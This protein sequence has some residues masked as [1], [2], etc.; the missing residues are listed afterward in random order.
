MSSDF[1]PPKFEVRAFNCPHCN[2]YAKQD[3]FYE[4]QIPVELSD[5]QKPRFA[6]ASISECE[7]CGRIAVWDSQIVGHDESGKYTQPIWEGKMVF[8][9]TSNA[10]LPNDDMPDDIKMDYNE[11]R[12]IAAVSP[13]GA[14]ALLRLCIQKL[15]PVLGEKGKNLDQDIGALVKKGLNPQIQMALDNVRVI[16]NEAVH[17]G[18]M[19]VNDNLEIVLTL[20]DLL[21]YIIEQMISIPKKNRDLFANLPERKLGAIAKRDGKQPKEEDN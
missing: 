13:R 5:L 2:V 4:P 1:V 17:P 20:F 3:W 16:G 15:M 14:A 19:D 8:P 6:G 11:A 9:M 10:P 18:V 7:M 21:N 12:T